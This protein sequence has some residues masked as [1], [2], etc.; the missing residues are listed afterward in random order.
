MPKVQAID[1]V[2][3]NDEKK[4]QSRIVAVKSD[5][6]CCIQLPHFRTS[7][8]LPVF[9][10]WAYPCLPASNDKEASESCAA[11]FGALDAWPA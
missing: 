11:C 6:P 7:Q 3:S 10:H 5:R 9:V 4:L 8:I 1:T 2:L